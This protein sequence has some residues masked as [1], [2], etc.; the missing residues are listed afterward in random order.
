MEFGHQTDGIIVIDGADLET[1]TKVKYLGFV[2]SSDGDLAEENRMRV[3]AA[4]AK[5]HQVSRVLWHRRMPRRL[6]VKIYK[7]YLSSSAIWIRMLS[8]CCVT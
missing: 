8:S 5:W 2:I 7:F 3:N 6:K 1:V 4:W